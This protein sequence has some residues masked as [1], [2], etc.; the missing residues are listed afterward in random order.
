[1]SQNESYRQVASICKKQLILKVLENLKVSDAFLVL[2][3]SVRKICFY[4]R[5]VFTKNTNFSDSNIKML[6]SSQDSLM[7]YFIF[8][9]RFCLNFASIFKLISVNYSIAI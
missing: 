1:M 4:C 9:K 8:Y 2:K 5:E 3:I 7:E 6:K